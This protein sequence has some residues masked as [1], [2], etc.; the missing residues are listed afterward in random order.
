VMGDA[1]TLASKMRRLTEAGARV[2]GSI[3][4]LMAACVQDFAAL[5][6]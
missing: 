2:F 1:G 4:T 6:T 5:R 3:E